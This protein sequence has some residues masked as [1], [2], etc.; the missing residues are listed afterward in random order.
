MRVQTALVSVF[1]ALIVA[2][3]SLSL[4]SAQHAQ[5]KHPAAIATPSPKVAPADEY[6]GRLKMS[7]LGI[8]NTIKDQSLKVDRDPEKAASVIGTVNFAVEAIHDWEHKY[9]RDPWVARSLF[10]L[11][12]FY[13]KINSDQGRTQAK[14]TMLWLVRDFPNS[15]Q[16]RLGK[17]ELAEGKVGVP[18]APAAGATPPASIDITKPVLGENPSAQASSSPKPAQQ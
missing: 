11:E 6:F 17:K 4:A 18:T 9:P 7:I 10:A 3:S 15:P 8:A 13:A 12:R 16:G 14:A 5:A 1:A 2:V